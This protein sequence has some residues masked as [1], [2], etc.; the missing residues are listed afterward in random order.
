M[1]KF[2]RRDSSCEISLEVKGNGGGGGLT[3]AS[4]ADRRLT[5]FAPCVFIVEYKLQNSEPP[6]T[7]PRPC[8]IK[9]E[10]Q[11]LIQV[12]VDANIVI[13]P[14]TRDF[15]TTN[16]I[17]Q[18]RQLYSLY[19]T[20]SF[21][22]HPIYATEEIWAYGMAYVHQEYHDRTYRTVNHPQQWD[23][24]GNPSHLSGPCPPH[25]A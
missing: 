16:I 13:L 3:R 9:S 22:V 6:V 21:K 5:S 12:H 19:S 7:S 20:A 18:P 10:T 24:N 4:G 17:L 8:K 11:A 14:H 1:H 25:T 23:D 15:S 2:T